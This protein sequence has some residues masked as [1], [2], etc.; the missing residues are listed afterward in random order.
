VNFVVPQD[1]PSGTVNLVLTH[2]GV[3]SQ[4]APFPVQ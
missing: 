1:A 4:P 3:S 2:A